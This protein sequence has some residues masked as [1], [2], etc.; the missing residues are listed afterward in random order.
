LTAASGTTVL[1]AL[2]G[3]IYFLGVANWEAQPV[4]FSHFVAGT[5]VNEKP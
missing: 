5:A 1:L 2:R 3:S 4:F